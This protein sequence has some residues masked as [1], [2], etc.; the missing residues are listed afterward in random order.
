MGLNGPGDFLSIHPTELKFPFELRKQSS[1]SM[2][3]TNRTDQYVAFKVKTTNPRKYSV[4]PNSGV[5]QPGSVTNVTVNMQALKEMPADMQCKDKF[6][7]QSVI[8]PGGSTVKDLNQQTF[9]KEDGKVVGEFKLRVAYIPANPPSPVPEEPEE[10]NS[11][12]S[13][14]VEDAVRSSSEAIARSLEEYIGRGTSEEVR[15]LFL[16]DA[17]SHI[18]VYLKL[19]NFDDLD[20]LE[21]TVEVAVC[22]LLSLHNFSLKYVCN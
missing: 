16:L 20:A 12:R 19:C 17:N 3:L 13:S 11:P 15:P 22:C 5:I 14:T 8:V 10:E 4:R 6:L 21:L 2:Q 9:E 7:V 18:K 1:C